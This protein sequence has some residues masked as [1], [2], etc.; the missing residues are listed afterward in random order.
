MY[1]QKYDALYARQ[2]VDKADSISIESQLEYCRYETHGNPS[3][4]FTDK[5]YSGK[6][7]NRP[8]FERLI[9]EIEQGRVSRVIVYKL[10]RIS[11]SILDFA[12]MME[13]FQ[14]YG[15]EF[16]SSTE[17]FDTSTPMGR[18]MLNICIVFAQLERETIQ[19]RV[20]DAFYSRNKKGFFMGGHI[21]YGYRK[22]P[23][24][25]DGIRTSKFEQ[26]PEEAEH[27]RLIYN[28]YADTANSLTGIVDYL[29]EHNIEHLRGGNW[30]TS[31]ISSMLSSPVYVRAD[32]DV[33]NFFKSE[34][35]VIHMDIEDFTGK[36]GCYLFTGTVSKS[37]K[38]T[39]L[40][41][42]ELI[43]APHEG[44]VPS[45]VW[46]KCRRRA[47]DSRTSAKTCYAK[48]SWLCG[49]VKCGNCGYAL[50]V[51]T[52]PRHV[53]RYF[54]CT[55]KYTVRK[56]NGIGERIYADNV[57]RYVFEK[58]KEKLSKFESLHSGEGKSGNPRENELKIQ[59]SKIDSEIESLLEKVTSAN[60]ILMNY[61]NEKITELDVMRSNLQ[62]ELVTVTSNMRDI[63]LDKI[64][65]HVKL[66]ESTPFEAKKEVADMLIDVI[67]I[68]NGN[69]DIH[70]K[71]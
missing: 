36:N 3:K 9:S 40:K 49:K 21:P 1:T 22:V 12:N 13:T 45:R 43:L 4:E 71:I 32:V 20:T 47:L 65:N 68:S 34:G 35:A 56:C 26:V 54:M 2:S 48:S 61:I 33:Y 30:R 59:I 70:W 27:I 15:V 67:K 39:D 29:N 31:Q 25:I 69:I 10:D 51:P 5:G 17:K 14:K 66:W 55:G 24:V 58:I 23:E 50:V 63:Y 46:L 38:Q 41:D 28:M 52:G 7:T 62:K 18:A 16:V 64:T 6:N 19:K 44:I 8:D 57:E 42:K 37:R 11:R 53:T 60:A